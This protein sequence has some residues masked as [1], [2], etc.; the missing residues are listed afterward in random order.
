[1]RFLDSFPPV[2]TDD[3]VAR[4]CPLISELGGLF[5]FAEEA[6]ACGAS[7]GLT[8]IELYFLGRG[9]VLG[10]AEPAAIH[11]TFGYFKESEV[12]RIWEAARAVTGP[13]AG[14]LAYSA[15]CRDFG[16]HHLADVDGLD[17]FC[18]AAEAV[19]TAASPTALPLFAGAARLPLAPDPPGRAM[20]LVT[21]LR[22]FRGGSHLLAV[23]SVGLDPKVAHYLSR[24]D[25][26]F[27]FGWDEEDV[28]RVTDDDRAR[29]SAADELTDRLMLPAFSVLDV[30]GGPAL[31]DGLRA[32]QT[33]LPS[34]PA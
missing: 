16:R 17:A 32:M 18:L 31:L 7:L 21:L 6:L 15:C 11:A 14:A 12:E 8:P 5:Y 28:P 33:R 13:R 29:V 9:G 23:A 19:A 25:V 22:E 2:T 1:V 24:P 30:S 20:Q 34:P 10:D 4:A 26:F 27:N 3:I